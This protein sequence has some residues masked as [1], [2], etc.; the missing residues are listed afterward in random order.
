MFDAFS[1]RVLPSVS[2]SQTRAIT[3]AYIVL[4]DFCGPTHNKLK[5]K[6]PVSGGGFL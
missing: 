2:Q 6:F 4:V 5:R 3:I 1:N